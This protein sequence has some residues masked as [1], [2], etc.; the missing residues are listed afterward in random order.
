MLP[1]VPSSI[2]ADQRRFLK[3]YEKLGEQDRASLIAFAE[4]LAARQPEAPVKD[5]EVLSPKQWPRPEQ[6][7]VVAAIKR[8][9]A[10]YPMLDRQDMFS[11]TAA[12]MSAHVMQGR[13]AVAV[14]D[15]LELVFRAHYER[16]LEKSS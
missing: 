3:L 7:S 13:T 9:S 14:I 6:E 2:R 16:Y 5:A 11:E 4:F 1:F 12:L 15:E 8:L 10:T